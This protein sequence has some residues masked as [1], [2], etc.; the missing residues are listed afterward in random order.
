M[1]LLNLDSERFLERSQQ[2]RREREQQRATEKLF[3]DL[4]AY[5]K[6]YLTRKRLK[7]QIQ[8]EFHEYFGEDG[9]KLN[10]NTK[11]LTYGRLLLGQLCKNDF[12]KDLLVCYT[13]TLIKSITST[14]K[15]CS[16]AT[17][18][19]SVQYIKPAS[20]HI[21][22][23][24]AHVTDFVSKADVEHITQLKMVV[25]L[26]EF[27]EVYSN[28]TMWGIVKEPALVKVMQSLC[29]KMLLGMTDSAQFDKLTTSI[30]NGLKGTKTAL[31]SR[32]L[33]QLAVFTFRVMKAGGWTMDIIDNFLDGIF[34]CPA[35]Y[36]V[37]TSDTLSEFE[38]DTVFERVLR[39]ASE[40][41]LQLKNVVSSVNFLGNF[42]QLTMSVKALFDMNVEAW[43]LAI[44][45]ILEHC[46]EKV[47]NKKY[48]HSVLGW[49]SQRLDEG[50]QAASNRVQYQVELLWSKGM[51]DQ[52]FGLILKVDNKK[53]GRKTVK[54]A[55]KE[56][57]GF[58]FVQKVIKI[59][60]T[61]G[62]SATV[63]LPSNNQIAEVC[64]LYQTLV[65]TF[66]A[67]KPDVLSGLCRNEKI[68]VGLWEF[69]NDGGIESYWKLL[70]LDPDIK[71]PYSSS[72]E[73]FAEAAHSLISILDEK[74]L[75]E[76]QKPFTLKQLCEIAS[77]CNTFCFRCIWE[78]LLHYQERPVDVLFGSVYQL[79]SLLLM[80][81]SRKS[82]VNFKDFWIV[83]EVKASQIVAEFEKGTQRALK[84]MNMLPHS[85][86]L[87]QR[88]VLF[89]KLVQKDKLSK[90]ETHIIEIHRDRLLEDGFVQLSDLSSK[91]LKGVIRVKFVNQQG[92][93]EVGIDQ[94]GVFKEFLE[95]TLKK[96]FDPGLNLFKN[97]ANN[98]LYPS[99][100]SY[101]H[102]NHLNLFEF[103]GKMLGKAV[104]EGI[105]IDLHLAP[106]LLAAVLKKKLWAFD[107]LSSLDPELYKNL[108]FVKHYD[109][110]VE[111]LGLTFALTE[112]VLGKVETHELIAGGSN[113]SVNNINKIS[114]IHRMALF[115]VVHQTQEQ[116]Q[117]FVQGFRTLISPQ[118]LCLFTSLE[119][120]YLVSGQNDDFDLEDLKKHTQYF[121]G[122]HSNH[123]VIRWLW[124]IME[125]EFTSEERHLFLKFGTSCSRPPLLGFAYLEPPFSIRCVETSDDNDQGDTLG[126]VIRGF[127]AI[128][129]KNPN[130]LPTA[131]T[132]F[133]LLKLPNYSKKSVLLEKLRYAIHAE[134]GFE[135]S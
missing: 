114:Y 27:L 21:Q 109:G 105:C 24:F 18:F 1:A 110:D 47:V 8:K 14:N 117:R 20:Q 101:I 37:L 65:T 85:V 3:T 92:L 107:E 16:F 55:Q 90:H 26:V 82:F 113:I 66:R 41:K 35:F 32:S 128:K 38:A 126:S 23:M 50:S 12:N 71:L 108:T 77:F 15:S 89:R 93:P 64:K 127:L 52:L 56:I 7:D 34:V 19:L 88:I 5:I 118:W 106:V 112:E 33:N 79:N 43:T 2:E 102:D 121:G 67:K 81:D 6:G 30:S 91:A 103:V 70:T 29:T 111:D 75:Y 72:L 39:R 87:K 76:N 97:T 17:L 83:K 11:L 98:V 95:L 94:D 115:R 28:P 48:F 122:F 124:E 134:T 125:K 54:L 133:N 10:A 129:R 42:V 86:P 62:L 119:L 123:R 78:E 68:L 131:S 61:K 132:C 4:G 99:S 58:D 60:S 9:L 104:Y 73:L 31:P 44:N 49:T 80:R 96:V 116:C 51:L 130:R 46:K 53:D 36:A 120:Q 25:V 22:N 69:I 45:Y 100:T 40:D 13:R 84:L 63:D 59:L 135:L 74:E 57:T